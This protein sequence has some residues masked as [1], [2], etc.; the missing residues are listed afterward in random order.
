MGTQYLVGTLHLFYRQDL[1]SLEKTNTVNLRLQNVQILKK[2]L[3]HVLYL[4]HILIG[5]EDK[6]HPEGITTC[7]WNSLKIEGFPQPVL[8]KI[9]MLI[10]VFSLQT[11]YRVVEA[12]R[13]NDLVIG[14][15]DG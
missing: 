7:D 6:I 13:S 5:Y 4:L 10:I 15:E 14:V 1:P 8:P 12:S 2:P 9:V 3:S 11:R